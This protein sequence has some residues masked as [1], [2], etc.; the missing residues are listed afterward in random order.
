MRSDGPLEVPIVIRNLRKFVSYLLGKTEE[1][2]ELDLKDLLMAKVILD[3]HRTRKSKELV[4]LPLGHLRPI[5]ALDRPNAMRATEAR[6]E[7]LEPHRERLLASGRLTC[8]DLAEILPS[9]SWIKTVREN[10]SSYL[11]YE[12][13]GRLAALHGV[14]GPEADLGVEAELYH[15]R[16]PKKIIRRLNRLRRLNGLI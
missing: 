5:H 7:A 16:K 1:V 8:D 12:G 11:V 14:F 10:D 13:N 15:F 2:Q 6:I 9:V 3:I 4:F